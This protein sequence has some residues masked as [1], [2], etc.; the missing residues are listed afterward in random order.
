MKKIKLFLA[1]IG[2]MLLTTAAVL[3]L[4]YFRSD[5]TRTVQA[6]EDIHLPAV[7]E[8]QNPETKL[9][10]PSMHQEDLE[11]EGQFDLLSASEDTLT[12]SE[13]LASDN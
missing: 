2:C 10:E 8:D 7:E 1:M 13:N 4:L 6:A 9:P 3:I 11:T 5:H 12:V